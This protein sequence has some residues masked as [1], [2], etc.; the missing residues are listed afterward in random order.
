MQAVH[1]ILHPT[2]FS[3]CDDKA[4]QVACALARDHGAQLIVLHVMEPARPSEPLGRGEPPCPPR[5]ERWEALCRLR[6]RAPDVWIEPVLRRGTALPAILGLAAEVPCDVIVMGM[7]G[8][9]GGGLP[10][11][12]GV[13]AEVTRLAPC[14]VLCVQLPRIGPGSRGPVNAAGRSGSRDR[15]EE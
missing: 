6:A 10:G 8:R 2:N 1:T 3:R 12:G 14:P 15:M 13:A 9:D 7:R 11:L 5:R 4:F